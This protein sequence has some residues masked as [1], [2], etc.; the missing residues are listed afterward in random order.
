MFNK[1]S[2][3]DKKFLFFDNQH[4]FIKLT[5]LHHSVI[6][7]DCIMLLNDEGVTIGF[8]SVSLEYDDYVFLTEVYVVPEYRTGSLPI[9]LEMFNFVK[10]MYMRPVRFIVHLENTRMQRIAE[11]IKAKV[12]KSQGVNIEYLAKN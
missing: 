5:N 9:L 10:N 11:F 2:Q 8:A 7:G 4:F 6:K 12:T 1:M 3:E